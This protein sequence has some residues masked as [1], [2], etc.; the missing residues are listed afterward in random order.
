[1]NPEKTWW[2]TST[3]PVRGY[4]NSWAHLPY[5]ILP[6]WFHPISIALATIYL[7]IIYKIMFS[8]W[9]F[10]VNFLLITSHLTG[11]SSYVS[12]QSLKLNM[13]KMKLWISCLSDSL[14][15][16][17]SNISVNLTTISEFSKHKNSG[18]LLMS[19]LHIQITSRFHCLYFRN[20]LL[21]NP[22]L[23]MQLPCPTSSLIQVSLVSH[24]AK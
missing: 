21:F 13:A 8:T 9:I 15:S 14:L 3:F 23:S 18:V 6:Y 19:T 2:N 17:F 1:M 22:F 7:M 10:P 24:L 4:I 20:I 11:I 16:K 12:K 5:S